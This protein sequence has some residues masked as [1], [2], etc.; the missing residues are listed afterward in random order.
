MLLTTVTVDH[1]RAAIAENRLPSTMPRV[2]TLSLGGAFELACARRLWASERAPAVKHAAEWAA[3][4]ERAEEIFL[5]LARTA[6]RSPAARSRAAQFASAP[7]GLRGLSA[8]EFEIARIER[9][10]D[11]I[12]SSGVE[13]QRRF[14]NSLVH[15]GFPQKIALAITMVFVEMADNV[16]Q[17]STDVEGVP[18]LGIWGYHVQSRWMS[19]AVADTGR[20]ILGS[21]RSVPQYSSLVD[22]N[23]ALSAA[24][25]QHA[26]RRVVTDPGHQGSFSTLGKR[27]AELNGVLRFRS[28]D[29]RVS[30]D[31]RQGHY[32]TTFAPSAQLPGFQMVAT[33]A[34]DP[35]QGEPERSL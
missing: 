6:Q 14:K 13:L 3:C 22:A 9:K 30:L 21:L 1:V 4:S 20:G 7:S 2:T 10:E 29:A 27:L 25:R 12:G 24:F 15:N 35:H 32:E 8:P 16:I 31:G 17:H 33:C 5:C 28:D 34:L 26:S 18:A 19:F 23:A 11:L